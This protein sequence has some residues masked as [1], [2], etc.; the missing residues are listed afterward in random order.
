MP[1]PGF[2]S[3][4]Q[5]F[6]PWFR[7]TAG[8]WLLICNHPTPLAATEPSNLQQRFPHLRSLFAQELSPVR[9]CHFE[10][11]S[12][13]PS[14]RSPSMSIP[15]PSIL[16]TAHHCWRPSWL[17]IKYIDLGY[18]KWES[19]NFFFT[20]SPRT[21]VTLGKTH[22]LASP[23][24][25][26]DPTADWVSNSPIFQDTLQ[27]VFSPLQSIKS[28]ICSTE[29][30][31]EPFT[32]CLFQTLDTAKTGSMYLPEA[33][34]LQHSAIKT[35]VSVASTSFSESYLPI[36]PKCFYLFWQK[37]S[38][39]EKMKLAIFHIKQENFTIFLLCLKYTSWNVCALY[40]SFLQN[41]ILMTC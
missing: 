22:V 20:R 37:Q 32:L 39:N 26:W 41:L 34:C 31:R 7:A 6:K 24:S 8:C 28:E 35:S 23:A 10:T 40:C 9:H 13:E 33:N 5:R 15:A 12:V 16:S 3:L 29:L 30:T 4:C 19:D 21:L 27:T 17:S 1:L 36:S 11:T 38:C 25:P 18:P 14:W 2:C